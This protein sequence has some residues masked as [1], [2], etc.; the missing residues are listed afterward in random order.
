MRCSPCALLRDSNN[1]VGDSRDLGSVSIAT[2][3]SLQKVGCARRA[4]SMV[5][6]A[7]VRSAILTMVLARSQGRPQAS[8]RLRVDGINAI[9]CAVDEVVTLSSHSLRIYCN[10]RTS[11]ALRMQRIAV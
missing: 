10:S 8:S 9:E 1:D 4:R 11:E 6:W 7:R 3:P 2:L 5:A